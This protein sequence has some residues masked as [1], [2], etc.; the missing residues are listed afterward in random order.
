MTEIGSIQMF[1][2]LSEDMSA[3]VPEDRLTLRIVKG[4]GLD[5]AISFEWSIEV[6]YALGPWLLL[7]LTSVFHLHH[8][9]RMYFGREHLTG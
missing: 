3:R 6:I 8:E 4:Q 2:G 7:G 9:S 1:H 5:V